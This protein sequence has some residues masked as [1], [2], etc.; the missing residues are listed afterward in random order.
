MKYDFSSKK[1]AIWCESIDE[2]KKVLEIIERE[3]PELMWKGS[4][5]PTEFYKDM[6]CVELGFA[7]GFKEFGFAKERGWHENE[8]DSEAE[9]TI[10]AKDYIASFEE[11]KD[12][13]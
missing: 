12:K 4:E 10:D 8:E 5:K 2:Q 1:L 11:E 6:E 7:F 9:Q 3:H 13:K